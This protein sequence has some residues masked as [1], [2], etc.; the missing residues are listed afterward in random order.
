LKTLLVIMSYGNA[1]AQVGWSWKH[2]QASGFDIMGTCPEDSTHEWPPEVRLVRDVGKNGYSSPALIKRWVNTINTVLHS[3][4]CSAYDA[5]CLT[6]YDG[7]FFRQPPEFTGG[8]W[9]H[10]AGGKLNQ[11]EMASRFYHTPHWFDREAGSKILEHGR[12]LVAEGQFELGSPDVFLGRI[13]EELKLPYHETN[14][15][16]VNGG[17]LEI[18]EYWEAAKKYVREGGYYCHGLRK[19]EQLVALDACKPI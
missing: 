5:F 8:L 4:S 2:Y 12:K 16:S 9:T 11:G 1:A 3:S 13:I 18:P 15:F 10:L 17:M 19:R 6:E 7:V 14:T